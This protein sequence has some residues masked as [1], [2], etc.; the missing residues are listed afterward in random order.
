MKKSIF[1]FSILLIISLSSSCDKEDPILPTIVNGQVLEQGSNKPLEGV[2]VV[3]MEGTFSGSSGTISYH[4]IDTFL[5]DKEGKYSYEHK[6]SANGKTYELWYFKDQ[7]FDI[8]S[9][10]NNERTTYIR[11]NGTVKANVKLVPF[12]W[13][14]IRVTNTNPFN[15]FDVLKARLATDS[16]KEYTFVGNGSQGGFSEMVKGEGKTLLRW[17]V[18][19]NNQWSNTTIDSIYCKGH[20]TTYYD[21]KY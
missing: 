7:Y 13:L 1:L 3:L 6:L 11:L 18:N 20:D 8:S 2:K 9:I 4:P 19:R 15:Q 12:A 16:G 14:S 17:S 21:L 5:T 10:S